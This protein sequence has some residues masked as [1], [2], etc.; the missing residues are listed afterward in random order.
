[1]NDYV[2]VVDDE[3]VNRKLLVKILEAEYEV[4]TASDGKQAL[5]M[6]KAQP[7]KYAAIVL[8]LVMPDM[9][10]FPFWKNIAVMRYC[11]I[12]RVIVSTGDDNIE[13]ETHSL[14]LGAWVSSASRTMSESFIF[15]CT[16]QSREV[17]HRFCV[18]YSMLRLLIR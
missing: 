18:S 14:E 9:N 10:G 2:L 17:V 11:R 8:D 7:H 4:E 13:C 12:F 1:M 6:L 16:M 5:Q 3:E 15:D